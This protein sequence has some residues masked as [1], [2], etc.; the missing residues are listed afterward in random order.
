MFK[1]F[2]SKKKAGGGSMSQEQMNNR[3][4]AQAAKARDK[5]VELSKALEKEKQERMELQREFNDLENV[6]EELENEKEELEEQVETLTSERD[7]ALN[8]A[9]EAVKEKIKAESETTFANAMK[10][11]ALSTVKELEE[12]KV[13]L[14]K[15]LNSTTKEKKQLQKEFDQKATILATFEEKMRGEKLANARSL[16]TIHKLENT[17]SKMNEEKEHTAMLVKLT[18]QERGVME[19]SD[20]QSYMQRIIWQQEENI[21]E[22]IQDNDRMQ[23]GKRKEWRLNQL[24]AAKQKLMNNQ[25]LLTHTTHEILCLTNDPTLSLSSAV[26]NGPKFK[27]L[28]RHALQA[29]AVQQTIEQNRATLNAVRVSVDNVNE[30]SFAAEQNDVDKIEQ[31]LESNTVQVN[32]LDSLG[33]SALQAACRR[34]N[35]ESVILLIKQYDADIKAGHEY[36]APIILAA[37]FGFVDVVEYLMGHAA[38]LDATDA[39]GRTALMNAAFNAHPECVKALLRPSQNINFVDNNQ[40]TALHVVCSVSDTHV[41]IVKRRIKCLHALLERKLDIKLEDRSGNTPLNTCGIHGNLPLAKILVENG[42][43]VFRKNKMKRN[44]AESGRY[45]KHV[46]FTAWI[47]GVLR[48]IDD[49]KRIARKLS[50]RKKVGKSLLPELS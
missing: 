22:L 2:G 21:K 30:L 35:M 39:E 37:R 45:Y 5:I 4:Q 48:K 38:P 33:Y 41:N 1:S 25:E 3:M 29:E 34:G 40:M 36:G 18:F 8:E 32:A 23:E 49:A 42:A 20:C 16:E 15:E 6:K 17:I 26:E 11:N 10:E 19:Q 44:V 31:I 9:S 14:E 13:N 7:S 43:N 24:E 27:L 12:A 47:N 28:M 46:K 50:S